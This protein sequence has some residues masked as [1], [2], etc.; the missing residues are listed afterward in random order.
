MEN[1]QFNTAVETI[2][3]VIN[4]FDEKVKAFFNRV[5]EQGVESTS[6]EDLYALTM[7]K[8]TAQGIIE[9]NK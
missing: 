8:I 7:L 9:L 4:L 6:D 1:L 2:E 3:S 5:K